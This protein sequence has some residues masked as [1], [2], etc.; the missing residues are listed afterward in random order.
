MAGFEVTTEAARTGCASHKS[1]TQRI[2]V[3]VV[4][5]DVTAVIDALSL[6]GG[7]T[8]TEWLSQ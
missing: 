6:G 8:G 2:D 4:A 7:G 3:C 1:V 5:G